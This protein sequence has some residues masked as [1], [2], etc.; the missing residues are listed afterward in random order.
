[1][2]IALND[3]R[4]RGVKRTSTVHISNASARG[5]RR[6]FYALQSIIL[7]FAFADD[8]L[9]FCNTA[10][11]DNRHSQKSTLDTPVRNRM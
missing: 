2:A 1:M 5:T 3:V 11:S 6:L 4:F 10:H 7:L 9:L 8:G